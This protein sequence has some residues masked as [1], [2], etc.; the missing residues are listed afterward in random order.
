V[1][2]WMDQHWSVGRLWCVFKVFSYLLR[3]ASTAAKALGL[4]QHSR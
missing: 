4:S 1:S 3:C 2:W